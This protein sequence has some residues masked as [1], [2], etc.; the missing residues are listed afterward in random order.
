MLDEVAA[1]VSVTAA[2]F[3][4]VSFFAYQNELPNL[5]FAGRVGHGLADVAVQTLGYAA[6]LAPLCLAV[7]ALVLFRHAAEELSIARGAA[8]LVLIGCTAVLLGVAAPAPP[9]RPVTL[10][11]GWLGGFLAALLAQAF[12]TV[13]TSVIVGAMAVLSFLFATRLSLSSL[14]G[15]AARGL[16]GALSRVTR[17][18]AGPAHDVRD[19]VVRKPRANLKRETPA[20]DAAPLIVLADGERKGGSAAARRPAKTL[21]EELP[22]GDDRYQ[23]PPTRILAAPSHD[24]VQIDEEGLRRSSQILE[25]KLADFG[26]DGKVVEVRP[27]PV[28]TTFDIEPAAGVKVNRITSLGDDLA[29]A[30]RVP[31]VRILAPVPGKAVV[32]IEVANPRRE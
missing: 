14:A 30:L 12:G 23:V 5:N 21:Q 29:M 16:A 1:V 24:D 3:M 15:S 13:G 28:I 26:I 2:A 32:G 27:G 6:Y 11:G 19:A 7:V 10:A 4:L 9:A 8:A 20:A 18:A 25:T 17:S 22:L 31:G